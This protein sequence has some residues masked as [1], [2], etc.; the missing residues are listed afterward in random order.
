MFLRLV[1]AVCLRKKKL[2]HQDQIRRFFSNAVVQLYLVIAL[3]KQFFS[4]MPRI[5]WE[6]MLLE[7]QSEVE[8]SWLKNEVIAAFSRLVIQ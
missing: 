4:Q 7:M 3:R 1:N 5:L 2:P 8:E 6:A